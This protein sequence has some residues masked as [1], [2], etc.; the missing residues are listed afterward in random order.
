MSSAQVACGI[1]IHSFP[2]GSTPSPTIDSNLNDWFISKVKF[3]ANY[4]LPSILLKIDLGIDQFIQ[5]SN[6]PILDL[7]FAQLIRACILI[8]IHKFYGYF[9]GKGTN[10]TRRNKH[11]Q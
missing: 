8:S 1:C 6:R 3:L 11:V 4:Q 2:K 5:I 9:V 7:I 10:A